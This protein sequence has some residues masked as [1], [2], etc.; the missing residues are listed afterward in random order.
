M[1]DQRKVIFERRREIMSDES[2]EEHVADMREEVVNTMVALHIPHNAYAEAWDVAGLAEEANEKLNIAPPIAAWA[3]E[4]GIGDEEIRER[5]L[6]A[7]NEAYAAK[8]ERNS[9]SLMRM[10]E[11][12]F[13]LQ[14]LDYLWRDHLIALDHLRQ[15]VGWRGMA[16]RDPL[17]EYKSEALEL[18]KTL[19]E[20]W[21]ERVT[22][23]LMRVD[24]TFEA[25]PSA[26]ME[27]PPMQMVHPS[28]EALGG[29]LG[30]ALGGA[31]GG[32]TGD[33]AILADLNARLAAVDFSAAPAETAPAQPRD[34]RNPATWG[35]VGRNESCPCGSGKKY[36]HCHG[37]LV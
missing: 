25:P 22:Q 7:A 14:A 6:A 29:I 24:V 16:Q 20:H 19:M 12:Q 15:V 18:F 37:A 30:G 9:P 27:L 2:V 13:V 36:K 11:K 31:L 34:P 10:I 32:G 35:K 17:N 3:A 4:E 33:P 8:V 5:L 1:N 23:Q 26:P 28:P 21:D